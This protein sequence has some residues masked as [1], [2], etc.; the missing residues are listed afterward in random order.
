MGS[1]I[2]EPD[3]R[4]PTEPNIP[5]RARYVCERYKVVIKEIADSLDLVQPNHPL[6]KELIEGI[7]N[8]PNIVTAA[9]DEYYEG[10]IDTYCPK[11]SFYNTPEQREHYKNQKEKWWYTCVFPKAP[12]PTYHTEDRLSSPRLLSWMQSN[13]DVTGNLFWATNVFA[14]YSGGIYYP[15]DDYYE[16][17]ADR[18]AGVNGDGYL[19]YPAAQYGLDEP[20]G[21][22]RLYAIRDGLEEYE[23]LYHLK[24]SLAELE[25][26]NEALFAFLTQFLYDGTVVNGGSIEVANARD[27]LINIAMANENGSDFNIVDYSYDRLNN[28]VDISFYAKDSTTIKVNDVEITDKT[29]YKEGHIFKASLDLEGIKN[30]MKVEVSYNGKTNVIN[31]TFGEANVIYGAEDLKTS[32]TKYNASVTSTVTSYDEYQSVLKL[33][34]G[35]VEDKKQSI[36]FVPSFLKDINDDIYKMTINVINPTD[37]D[38][39][40]SVGNRFKSKKYDQYF[41][42]NISLKPGMNQIEVNLSYTKFKNVGGLEYIMFVF[43][44]T[45]SEQED[46][47]TVYVSNV[48]L[49][50]KQGV[51]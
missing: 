15:I 46:S 28:K 43:G 47:K 5:W 23:I 48:V 34:V 10:Y 45:V 2:D 33:D 16:G 35:K 4:A 30:M 8:I 3:D 20:A 19:F 39:L 26:S 7:R 50:K 41:L 17:P 25:F 31:H 44:D 18:Y 11:A 9:Y 32:F 36:K 24:N 49:T 29:V 37:E 6:H 1:I 40:F 14:K 42:E 27:D 13:Y 21:C 38:I 12:F 51:K 22:L